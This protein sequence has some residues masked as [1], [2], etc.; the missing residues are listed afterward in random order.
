MKALHKNVA[1]LTGF[2]VTLIRFSPSS[3]AS[4]VLS[5]ACC[6][7]TVRAVAVEFESDSFSKLP[8]IGAIA[9]IVVRFGSASLGAFGGWVKSNSESRLKLGELRSDWSESDDAPD[10]GESGLE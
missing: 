4:D 3:D 7:R 10:S 1:R 9:R 5:L 8:P 6:E 2:G